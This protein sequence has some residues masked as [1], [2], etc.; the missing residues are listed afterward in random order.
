MKTRI[1]TAVLA[2]AIF[3]P[4]VIIGNTPF[5]ILVYIMASIALH[6][7]MRM[8]KIN[9]FSF[10][11]LL[12]FLFLWLLLIPQNLMLDVVGMNFSKIESAL[13]VV[14]LLLSYT[15]ISKNNFTFDDAGFTI[16]STLY[17]GVGFYYLIET[18][19]VGLSYIF[20]ALFVIWATDTGA[21]FIGKALGKNKLWPEISPNKT[22][23]G[24]IGGIISAIVVGIVFQLI[25]PIHSSIA[26]VVVFTI[27]ISI[28]GQM[29]DLV[30]SALKR[31]YSVKDSGHIL[32]GHGGI[33]DRFDSLIFVLPILHFLQFI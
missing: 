9:V 32:P 15:V 21:Y 25:V 24:S 27:I 2:A 33:L 23:E 5:I 14:M 29:G 16:L 17:V 19:M 12:I 4:V 26:I 22:I 11:G 28:F 18:R 20:F 6:E 10:P 30:E 1:L 13:I 31:H 8:K 3:L 7:L